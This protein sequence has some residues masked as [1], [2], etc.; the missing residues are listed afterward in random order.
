MRPPG[1]D[2]RAAIPPPR[3]EWDRPPAPGSFPPQQPPP[4]VPIPGPPPNRP[5][6][7]GLKS[8]CLPNVA[9]A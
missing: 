3:N 8:I 5:P 6:I 2:P 9:L 4:G 1:P 7:T